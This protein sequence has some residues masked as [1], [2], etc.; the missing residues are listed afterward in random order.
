MSH[1]SKL[2]RKVHVLTTKLTSL[3]GE[4][5]KL[6]KDTRE[7]VAANNGLKLT[8]KEMQR[9]NHMLDELNDELKKEIKEL[10]HLT[11]ENLLEE[12]GEQKTGDFSPSLNKS[13]KD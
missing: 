6:E 10:K 5:A 2:E 12:R 11:G 8:C 1:L 4:L 9:E 13:E 7:M 3:T